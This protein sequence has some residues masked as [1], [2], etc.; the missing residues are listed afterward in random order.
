MSVASYFET[1]EYG[2]APEA[3][4]EAR[5]WLARHGATFGHFIAGKFTA[6]HAGK[7]LTTTEPATGKT[8]A[9][10][11]Q[12]AAADV[13]AAVSAA[14]TAQTAWAKLGGH[15]RARH[16]Y[17]LARMLQRHARLF[18]VLE[19]I[20]NGKPIRETRDL[21]VPL[22]ARHFLYHAGWAQL[23]E[24]EFADQM[25][26]GVIGQIIPWNFPL[27]MLAWKIAPALAAG[28]TVVLKPAEFTSLTALLFA[29]LSAE[30]GLPPGVLNVVTGDGATGALLV[31]SPGVDK[32]AFT[33]STEVGRLIRQSTAGTG[34][35]LTLE[36]GG[37]SPFIVFD[38]ADIDGAVEGVVDA[39]WFNQGQVCCAGS[40]LLLQEGIAETFR[41]RLIRRMETLRVGM[42]L[43]KAID[44]GAVVAPVQLER[45]KSLVETGVREGAEKYQASGA[46]PAE[47]CFYPPTLLWNV[48]PSSTV[49]TEEIFGPVLVAMTF[50]TADEAVIL[51][52][53]TRYGL[54]A[55]VWSETI[56][57]ALDIAPKLL[58]GVVWVNATNLFDASVGFGGY[59]ES[60]F[61]REG[62]REGMYEYLKPKAWSGRKARAKASPLPTASGAS[63]GFDVPPIDRTAKLFVGGKQVRPDGN[64]SRPVLSP[65]GRRLGEA[66][67]GNRKD[68][69]NAVAAARSAESWA[70]AT[71][72]NRAQIL[73]YL[74]ENLSARGDEFARRIADMTG[75]SAAKARAEVDASIERLFSYGA[76][77]DKF[78]GS[79]HA[80]PLRGVALAMHEPIG[81]V[82]VACPDEAPLLAFISLVA[83]LV[84]MGNRVVAVPSERHPLAATDFYQVLETSD[85]SGGVVNIVTGDHSELV[86]VL[87]EHDDVDA[88]WAF[89]SQDASAAAERLSTGN[90]KRTLVDHGLALDWYD[91]AASE[92]PIL[93]RH[94]VQVKN[95]WIPYGD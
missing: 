49:A 83:P 56:G 58:A 68:I 15:G 77:A 59:R 23:Q 67:E 12:G 55:S 19:A 28:N 42:P 61:G 52:N 76:W 91:K 93:L 71:A 35:S 60:G 53:N 78:E 30:A 72:H 29:E 80:P 44:M 51:A 43:D 62:G 88:L 7:H 50:R 75:V 21:D 74:A 92:G 36:L 73:Y 25:P 81:V 16:L 31:E 65:K 37:K 87:A 22:A 5:A 26:V 4:G 85:V 41:R 2:P 38:D 84:A 89:G 54:A 63:A 8:L 39:I 79:I 82:G 11:A 86:K 9:R 64:Y 33:G 13:E 48:H 10:I 70:R 24:R 69:R 27:L 6:P 32:I 45:I 90:L 18:A 47:G 3:D 40:R 20:D 1:M 46:I 34:K 94:A 57:L 95:I 14:R 17:A 66:G